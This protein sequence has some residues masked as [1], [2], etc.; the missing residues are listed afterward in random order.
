MAQT[1]MA[2]GGEQEDTAGFWS[3]T[4]ENYAETDIREMYKVMCEKILEE[5]ASYLRNGSGWRV[6]KRV[7][8]EDVEALK[9]TFMK[10]N[11]YE[12]MDT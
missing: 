6:K 3:V 10:T 1:D 2:T 5:F 8:L 11:H 7:D 4:M 12:V 9:Y